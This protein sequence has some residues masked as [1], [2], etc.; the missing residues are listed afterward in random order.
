MRP[1]RYARRMSE[2]L[3]QRL[4]AALGELLQR[5]TRR[6]LYEGLVAGIGHGLDVTSYPVLSGL[7][8]IGP[9]TAAK[10]G[11]EIGLDRSGVSRHATRL[12]EGGLLLRRPDPDDARGTLLALTPAGEQVVAELRRRLVA[13]LDRRLA[14]WPAGAAPAFVA[15][16]ERFVESCRVEL[17][18]D[19]GPSPSDEGAGEVE[20][21]P[22]ARG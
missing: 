11:V 12:V 16:L 19:A 21:A 22:V 13:D 4:E 10:L 3:G 1:A 18:F 8:R 6:G 17:L 9:V 2:D 14:E 5:R 20:A 7:A 15:G